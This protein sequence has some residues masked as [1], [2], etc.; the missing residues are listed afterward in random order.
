MKYWVFS[1]L[2]ALIGY[3]FGS[4]ST[5]IL[6]S[7]LVFRSNLRRLGKPEFFLPNFYRVYGVKGFI[8]L[9]LVEFVKDAIPVLLGGLL[10][11]GG[12]NT[13]VG[14]ALAAF[15]V[16]LG[17]LYPLMYEFRG[18]YA[19]AA[20]GFC[21]L[22]ISPSVGLIAL[23]VTVTVM[24]LTRY[25]SLASLAGALALAA[26]SILTVNG[27][28]LRLCLFMAALVIVRCVPGILRIRTKTEPRLSL[29]KDISY[30]F[31]ERF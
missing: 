16:V 14:R 9:A 11:S 5:R 3:F 10:F 27:L 24:L 22:F 8:K 31:D 15:C 29:R 1:I 12:E 6:A 30:K 4:L 7:R 13:V 18:S 23:I 28:A 19:S 26:A 20:I 21:L 17:R 2:T 25:V